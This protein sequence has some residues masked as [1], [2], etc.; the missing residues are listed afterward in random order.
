MEALRH[1]FGDKNVEVEEIADLAEA[2]YSD[3]LKGE[4][5]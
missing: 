3:A 2:D 5:T 1:Q 4:S